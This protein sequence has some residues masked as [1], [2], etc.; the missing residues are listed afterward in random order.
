MNLSTEMVRAGGIRFFVRHIGEGPPLLLL[1]GFPE[2]GDSWER[3]WSALADAGFHVMVPDLK[4]YGGSDKPVPGSALGDYRLSVLSREIGELIGALGYDKAHVVGHDW[5]GAI[6]SAM[7]MTARHRLDRVAILNAPFRRFVPWQ[8][9]HMW[10]FNLPD[11]PERRFY[12]HPTRFIRKILD[13]WTAQPNVFSDEDVLRYVRAFQKA[14]SISCAFEYYRSLRKDIAF[15]GP[16]LLR[17]HVPGGHPETTIIWGAADPILTP[18]V[19]RWAHKD[20]PGSE[21]HLIQGAGHF[22]QREAAEEVNRLLVAFL[23]R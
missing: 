22:V 5:G 16:T 3:N 15:L 23:S 1:H 9:N 12:R 8:M 10:L 7:M 14:G 13:Q 4:G 19:G 21:L 11:L 2:L 20:I 6:T 17:P 18:T